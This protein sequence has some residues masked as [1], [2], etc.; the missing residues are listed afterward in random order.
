MGLAFWKNGCKTP[1]FFEACPY[2]WKLEVLN[3]SILMELG[4]LFFPNFIFAKIRGH[5]DLHIYR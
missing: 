1:P 5:L 4:D 3:L 2:T